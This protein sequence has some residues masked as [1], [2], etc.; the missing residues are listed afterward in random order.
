MHVVSVRSTSTRAELEALLTAADV[1]SLHCPLTDATR[2]LMDR[3]AF[4]RMKPGALLVNCARGAIV[5][6]DAVLEALRAGTLGGFGVDAHWQ[7]P[8]DPADPL[9]RRDDVVALPHVGG[10]TEEAFA[11]IAEVVVDNLARLRRGE[12]LRHRVA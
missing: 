12:P 11:R 9:Y 1:V 4:A 2:G 10:T 7:E 6:R 8:W 5:D 3:A